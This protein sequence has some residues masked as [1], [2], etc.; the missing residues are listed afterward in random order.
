MCGSTAAAD[1]LFGAL[2][3]VCLLPDLPLLSPPLLSSPLLSSLPL[4]LSL[5][6][7]GVGW[8]DPQTFSPPVPHL[9]PPGQKSDGLPRVV[10]CVTVTR[11]PQSTS[12][13]NVR[14]LASLGSMGSQGLASSG[15]GSVTELG[16]SLSSSAV[17]G[18]FGSSPLLLAT[19]SRG[20]FCP[21]SSSSCPS[22]ASPSWW[23]RLCGAGSGCTLFPGLL[24]DLLGL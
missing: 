17:S 10:V 4:S 24:V 19:W 6:F 8:P 23:L 7:L 15:F 13:A 22:C 3:F 12:S 9:V 5:S 21:S 2:V 11:P 14:E 1:G 16:A 18:V 20:A